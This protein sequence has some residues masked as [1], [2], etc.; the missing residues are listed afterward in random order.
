MRYPGAERK[1]VRP[2][3]SF[4]QYR[5]MDI[6]L[7]T[8]IGCLCEALIVFASTV[9]FPDQL[10]SLS[11]IAAVSGIV[12]IRWGIFAAV[13]AAAMGLLHCALLG[14]GTQQTLIYTLGGCL[15]LVL[16][17]AI[18]KVSWQ[19][20]SESGANCVFYG[21]VCALLVQLGRAAAALL[22]GYPFSAAVL[23]F[24]TDVLSVL[25]AMVVI[26][27]VRHLDGILEDQKHYL[28]RVSREKESG[29]MDE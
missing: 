21:M 19:T 12:M 13:P 15:C 23:Y 17:P 7:L 24:T 3:L 22:C 16:V 18:G 26:W 11:V 4:R 1:I 20:I 25:F 5:A 10:Y 27:I 2:I 6:F 28:D 8:A 29:G 14:A 9:W